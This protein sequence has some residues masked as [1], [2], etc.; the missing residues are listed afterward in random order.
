MGTPQ[1]PLSSEQEVTLGRL[2]V[3]RAGSGQE[4]RAPGPGWGCLARAQL[5]SL[6]GEGQ[7]GCPRR[8]WAGQG[9]V[10]R[11]RT[12]CRSRAGPDS[13]RSSRGAW[14]AWLRA[15]WCEYREPGAQRRVETSGL[16]GCC[17]WPARG[18]LGLGACLI[19]T[20]GPPAPPGAPPQPHHHRRPGDEPDGLEG[21]RGSREMRLSAVGGWPWRLLTGNSS[22]WSKAHDSGRILLFTSFIPR[23]L[24]KET[25]H[26]PDCLQHAH[27][28]A[29]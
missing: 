15:P 10:G 14:G 4:L 20:R 25:W 12:P 24:S 8:G 17:C 11:P 19:T 7:W 2:L 18:W 21:A 27:P 28:W 23:T 9:S 6:G 16:S 5:R 29:W 3:C 13:W 1:N 26:R 22:A